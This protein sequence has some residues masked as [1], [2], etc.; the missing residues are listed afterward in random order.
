MIRPLTGV[1]A[2]HGGKLHACSSKVFTFFM[3]VGRWAFS[4]AVSAVFWGFLRGFGGLR[5]LVGSRRVTAGA[6]LARGPRSSRLF[7]GFRHKVAIVEDLIAGSA[8]M[9]RSV[10]HPGGIFPELADSA[11]P[12]CG[13]LGWAN[14][15][16]WANDLRSK[17]R[18]AVS[19]LVSSVLSGRESATPH[20]GQSSGDQLLVCTHQIRAEMSGSVGCFQLQG[21]SYST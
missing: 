6:R 15:W 20:C 5:W 9:G 13:Q 16:L 3:R 12:H 21:P 8:V 14:Y 7:P 19:M 4:F 11:T 1:F 18:M 17:A 2:C 10:Q